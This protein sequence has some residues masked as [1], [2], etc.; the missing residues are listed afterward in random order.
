MFSH[1]WK[2]WRLSNMWKVIRCFGR[3]IRNPDATIPT[4]RSKKWASC[5]RVLA[6]VICHNREFLKVHCPIYRAQVQNKPSRSS[7][8]NT[9]SSCMSCKSR[10][11]KS[12]GTCATAKNSPGAKLKPNFL[13]R[14]YLRLLIKSQR[15][16]RTKI[17]QQLLPE[18]LQ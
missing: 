16:K 7:L 15:R 8:I 9:R 4:R 1:L 10:S 18:W 14:V 2:I 6:S 17:L 13:L 11:F 5:L 3:S 12:K